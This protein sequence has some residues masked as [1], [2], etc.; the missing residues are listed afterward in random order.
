MGLL[1]K[2]TKKSKKEQL[3]SVGKSKADVSEQTEEKKTVKKSDVSKKEEVLRNTKAS[4][5]YRVIVRPQISEKATMNEALN[6]YTFVVNI[7]ATK[8]DIKR[9]IVSLYGVKPLTIRTINREGKPARFGSTR[10][11]RSDWKKAV[12][13][14]PKGSV[15]KAH[16]GV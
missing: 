7:Q 12:V 5:A 3:E 1:D 2:W 13:T 4:N 6:K 14:L 11:R 10:G 15:I 16:E 9:A 8:E